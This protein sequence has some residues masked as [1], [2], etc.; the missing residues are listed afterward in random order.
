VSLLFTPGGGVINTERKEEHWPLWFMKM[1]HVFAM[2]AGDIGLGIV[3]EHCKQPLFG[4]N[5]DAD[6]FWKMECA[7]RT[8]IGRNPQSQSAKRKAASH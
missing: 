2:T 6:N 5:A 7:C 8:Y 4:K 3:C 1:L